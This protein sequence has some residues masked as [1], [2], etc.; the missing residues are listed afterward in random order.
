MISP[1]GALRGQRPDQPAILV[2][3]GRIGGVFRSQVAHGR[4]FERLTIQFDC[5]TV[6][7]CPRFHFDMQFHGGE[8]AAQGF[9]DEVVMNRE[10]EGGTAFGH[11]RVEGD[12][13]FA[14]EAVVALGAIAQ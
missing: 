13:E 6:G 5:D 1:S 11:H 8:M 10:M 4:L 3:L 14:A 9:D 2:Y 12:G 7:R